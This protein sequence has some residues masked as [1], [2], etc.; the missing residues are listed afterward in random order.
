MFSHSIFVNI[1]LLV[2]LIECFL[3]Q[4]FDFSENFSHNVTDPDEH[5]DVVQLIES[6]G[7]V[8]ETHYVTT[9]DGYILTI[10]RIV[11]PYLKRTK[12]KPV[13]LQHGLLSS[14]VDWIINAPALGIEQSK[15]VFQ[16]KTV[17]NNLGFALSLFGY[18]VWLTNSRGNTYGVNHTKFNP[19]KED[20]L[21]R[22]FFYEEGGAF[23]PPNSVVNKL[24]EMVCKDFLFRDICSNLLFL[25]AGYDHLQLNETRLPVYIAH[26][27]AGTS[28]WN[29]VH[30]MQGIVSKKFQKFDYGGIKNRLKYGTKTPPSY[31][32]TKI[33]TRYIA[34][35][36]SQNDWLA[37]PDDVQF[38][39]DQVKGHFLL[40]YKVQFPKWNHI[41]YIWGKEAAK[42][43]YI[44]ILRVLEKF[45]FNP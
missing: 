18:D 22:D 19:K 9:D 12:R 34:I 27:P 20:K 28:A 29:L 36:H 38:L 6:R 25:I 43:V 42:Y 8:A 7:F 45:K 5:R 40:D 13:M 17:S 3:C 1:L 10:H 2:T 35:F 44:M 16:N 15:A 23:L 4:N 30:F 33:D 39:R 37:D 21:I 31:N 26:A 24:A 14:G 32:L 11:N 41:D